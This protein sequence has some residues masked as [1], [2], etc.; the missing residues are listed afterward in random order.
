MEAK[1]PDGLVAVVKRDCATCTLVAPLLKDLV[2]NNDAFTVYV[3]DD[4]SFPDLGNAAPVDD[5][6]LTFSWHNNIE[7]VPTL[8]EVADG[9][10]V[11]RTVGWLRSDWQDYTGRKDL[12][13]DLPE[14]RPGCGSLSVDPN[15]VDELEVRFTGSRLTSRRIEFAAMEDEFEAAFD[16]GW[17]DGLPVVPPTEARVLRML[18]GTGREPGEIVATVP[19]NL[20]DVTVEQVAINAVMAGCKP[21]YLP[22]VLAA[23]EAAC[24]DQFNMHGLIATTYFSGPVIVVNGPITKRIGMNAGGNLMGQG[25]R[26]NMTI[27]RAL[28]LVIRNIGGGVP[29]KVDM[30]MHGSPGK[31]SFCFA[32]REEDSPF[33]SLAQSRGVAADTSAVTLFAGQGP[34][35]IVDQLSRDPDSLARSIA[36]VLRSTHH[37]KL[38]I[39]MDAMLVISP[40]HGKVFAEAGWDRTALAE[41]LA[42]LLEVPGS[43]LIRGAAFVDE[44]LPPEFADSDLPK[45]R[46]GGLPIVFG[47]GDAGLFSSVISGWVGGPMGSDLVTRTIDSTTGASS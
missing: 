29:G 22:V 18:T 45:F 14:M 33:T 44:G 42:E 3:Q 24:T 32:E 41:R 7:T 11:R 1:L 16:R 13:N 25:N 19:P 34:T 4:L 39:G 8:I 35:P 12:G 27:G 40:E 37:P 10:E 31:L 38:V 23:V 9:K 6:D 47:G 21:E 26:A 46:P 28:N 15:L 17:T 43:E 30:A 2:A 36:S 20:V 5:T